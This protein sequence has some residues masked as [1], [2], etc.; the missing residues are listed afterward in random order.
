MSDRITFTLDGQEVEAA[1]GET[2]WQV[3]KR[4]GT[5]IPH[6]CH[7]DEPG[8]RPDGNCRA[9]V[10]EVEGERTLTASCIRMPS[11]GMVV[12]SQSER[13]KLSQN[14]VTELLLADQPARDQAH[15]RSSH[16]WSIADMQGLSDSRFPPLEPER[17]PALDGSHAAMRINLDA[18]IHCD[19]CVRACREVQVNDVIGMANRGHDAKIVFDFDDPMGLSTCVGCGECVQACPTGAMMEASILD[20]QERGDSAAID[21]EVQS[22]CP[23]CGVGCQIT[24]KIRTD[25]KGQEHIAWVD[26]V[27]GPANENRL[28]IK[29]RFGF[30]YVAHPHRLTKPMIRREDAPE[31]GLNVDPG[32]PWTHFR[33]ATWEEALDVAAAGLA[34]LRAEHGGSVIAGFGSA[35][36]P[37]EEAYLFQKL[38]RTAFGN[39]NVDHCTRL[40]HASSVAALMENVGSG[41]VTATFNEI[42]NAEVAIVIGANPV[43]NHPVAAT[44]FKQFVKNGGKLIYMDPRGMGLRKHATHTLQF[45]P[46]TD[47]AMLNAIM[48]VIVEEELY[49]RQYIAAMTEGFEEQ[50]EHLKGFSPEKMA[51]ICGIEAETLR[52]VARLFANAS[53]SMIFWGM[54][55]SQH[56]HGT[57][58]SRCLIS[59]A[60]MCG[61][62]GRPGTGLHPLRGQNNVQ[63]ASDAGL[64]P[65]FMP[66]YQS[67]T[68]Q[69]VREL[70]ET[71]WDGEWAVE[72]GIDPKPGLTVVEIMD[73]ALEGDIKGMYIQGENPAM[74]DP[75]VTHVRA[76]FAKMDWL[77][78]QDIFLTET[79]Y[80]ADVILPA[81]AWPEKTGTVTNTNRQVQMGRRAL[82]PPGD[83][84]E[85]FWI[86][87]EMGKR[88]GLPWTYTH[89]SEVFEEM[90]KVMPSLDNITWERLERENVV[91]YPS[92]SPE[93]PGQPIVF[94]DAFPR[95]GGRAKFT[96]AEIVPPAEIPDDEFPMILTTGRQL[97]HWHTGSMTRRAAVLNWAEPEASASL[98]P[99]TLRKMGIKPGELI[100]VATRRGE[101]ELMARED[102]AIATDMVFIPFAYVEAAANVLTNPQLDPYGKIPEFKFSACRVEKAQEQ[103]AAE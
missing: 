62:V 45:R 95:E 63:G 57:D 9:C 28:C 83:A 79:A 44:Y 52:E 2:I 100:R 65:M 14:M 76:A 8:Y 85:D 3:A 92:L 6:L 18:C 17:V 55:V 25:E 84:R 101:I 11:E 24:Y 22:V 37:N 73:A 60:L 20:D 49:D 58:N 33:E 61:H 43:E 69:E 86:L 97:E 77:V 99:R 30:D 94:G 98:H 40:C 7:R 47:V 103:V 46:G 21:R 81:S 23:Y 75:D 87:V 10:V 38:I 102:R 74:S 48:H 34:R 89:P 53:A 88:L 12:S 68:K 27:N 72:P 39:N 56:V 67:V 51:P 15:D 4:Q 54:G 50:V 41:A 96:P 19:L 90:K 64:I 80:Y 16:F 1:P 5:L 36:C 70:F 78:V 42:A 59:L 82:M 26:G 91:M 31:K 93:D 32:N 35:K 29:G 13:A 71:T 66:D